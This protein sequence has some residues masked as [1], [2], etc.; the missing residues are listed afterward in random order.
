MQPDSG[1]FQVTFPGSG[2]DLERI[3]VPEGRLTVTPAME[4]QLNERQRLVLAEV[5]H[6]DSV[7]SG[8]LVKVLGVTYDTANRDLK[9]LAEMGMLVRV[10]LG[11][12]AKYVLRD[13]DDREEIF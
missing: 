12:A 13:S 5:A 4:A 11:R 2:E 3:R 8:W 6:T 1:Y 9:G 10:G 7:S